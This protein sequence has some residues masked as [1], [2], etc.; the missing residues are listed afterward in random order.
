MTFALLRYVALSL[1]FCAVACDA[2]FAQGTADDPLDVT[3]YVITAEIIP[4]TQT[5]SARAQVTVKTLRPV[6][7]LT[8]E[9]NGSLEVSQVLG[10]NLEP[11]QFVQDRLK[12]LNLRIALPQ[13]TSPGQ[14]F[15]VTIEYSGQLLTAEGGV[16]STKRLA[17]IG[18]D[19]GYLLY[20]GRWFPF[21]GYASDIATF[22]VNLTAPSG[23]TIV[24]FGD[25]SQ[26]PLTGPAIP[27]LPGRSGAKA[28][29]P[30]PTPAKPDPKPTPR[31]PTPR[32]P[33]SS[34][35]TSARV[36]PE[37]FPG[38]GNSSAPQTQPKPLPVGSG[39]RIRHTFTSNTAVLP[40]TFA[41][42]R[43]Q[44]RI[45]KRGDLEVAAYFPPGGEAAA[46]RYADVVA[47][48]AALYAEKF[49]PYAFGNRISV[50]QIDDESLE[51]YTTAGV[52]LLAKR[53][54]N[55]RSTPRELLS[56]E[57]AYQWWGQSVGLRSFDDIWISQGLATYSYLLAEE[58]TRNAG[59]VSDLMRDFSERALAFEGQTS[60]RKAPSELDD[61][62]AAY[63]SVVYY[64]GAFVFRMLRVVMGETKFFAFLRNYYE[65]N[66]GKRPGIGDLEKA[67]TQ[68]NGSDLRLFFSLWVDSTG[69]PEFKPD[70]Q[71][72][73]LKDGTFRIRGSLEQNLESFRM[74]V[75]VALEYKG[76]VERATIDFDGRSADFSIASKTEPRDLI[77]DPDSKILR[78][79]EEIRIAVVV[80][81]GIQHLEEEEYAEAQQQF[82]AAVKINRRSS[83]AY[84][85][86]G[87]LYLRQQNYEKAKDA[88]ED[89]LDGDLRP[90]SLEGLALLRKGNI[91]DIQGQRDRAVA[92]Y[93][94]VI[95]LGENL[96]GVRD[97]AERY[98]EKPCTVDQAISAR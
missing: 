31:K 78:I 68:T 24:G 49:G 89:A 4:D 85:N 90:R 79:S 8:F 22:T 38:V 61:Q 80:R 74:P 17:Y 11:L 48:S 72:L 12:D 1:F 96:D 33:P 76:G 77:I 19:D 83:L 54:F 27:P 40:G 6:Q 16:L 51:S 26:Q 98:L 71:I 36:A 92:E 23:L 7:S 28:S 2:I 30:A 60:I 15:A 39:G 25:H 58:A 20:A 91:F 29:D 64:K 37:A 47:E 10:P 52:T 62:S 44:T 75:D 66:R 59:G 5:L 57:T 73:R 18:K 45:L 50:A 94:K 3:N 81:R 70:Y 32:R 63:R 34:P 43:Y 35:F 95:D 65:Q 56:R 88:F 21:H 41:I 93:K 69:V 55:A 82:E 46:E 13:A 86:L 84:Y 87:L 14:E 67:A 97:L 9:L 53:V 42:G